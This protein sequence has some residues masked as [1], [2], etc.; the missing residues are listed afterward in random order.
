[1][2][3]RYFAAA[4]QLVPQHLKRA[5][6]N[7]HE[8]TPQTHHPV[9]SLPSR[10]VPPPVD[11][12]QDLRLVEAIRRGESAAWSTLITRYQDRLFAVCLRMV[13]NRDLAQD[14]TQDAFV[15]IIQGLDSFDARAK[16][17]T[18]MIRV[19]MNVCLSRLRS[20]KLRRHASLEAMTSPDSSRSKSGQAAHFEQER[21][22][23]ADEGVEAHEDR[24]RVLAAIRQLE[25]DQRAVLILCDCHGQSYEQIAEVMGVAVGTIKSRLFRARTALRE[26]VENLDRSP[27]PAKTAD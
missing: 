8:S 16:L 25:P 5:K 18:W 11:D 12:S 4:Q 27:R 23:G 21:E 14:L 9:P 24:T 7:Y 15:K 10:R 17:S 19:T 1:L 20:E 26:A 6:N 13:H 2:R 22:P 3:R